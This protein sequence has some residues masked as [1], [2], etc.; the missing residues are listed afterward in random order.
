M[1]RSAAYMIGFA[2]VVCV[3][4]AVFVSTAAVSLKDRQDA[5][6]ANFRQENVLVAAGFVEPGER[7]TPAEI[8]DRSRSIE[9]HVIELQSGEE[10][11]AVD[12]ATFD[13]VKAAGD[14]TTSRPAPANAA[15]V[16]RLPINA[17]VYE[18]H[19]EAGVLQM[20]ILPVWGKGL[21]STLRGFIALESDLQ[22]VRG[23]TFYDHKET[24]GLGGEVDNPRWKA[25]WPGRKA[26]DQ[27]GDVAISVV[28]G[29]A[30]SVQDDPFHVDGL[31]GATITSRGVTNLIQFWLGDDGYGPY[32][33]RLRG[34]M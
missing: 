25:L 22:T 14:P 4:C 10:T 15:G 30:G 8:A 17:L 12:A 28:K 16:P 27:E 6:V 1:Q 19:D 9:P 5:N 31:S 20:V 26:F 33:T 3:V 21:W 29:P 11:T 32:L 24:P 7:L 13:V 18:V 23:L 34:G 2:A